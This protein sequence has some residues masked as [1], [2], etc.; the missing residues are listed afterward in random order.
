ML[1]KIV[2]SIAVLWTSI[3]L[4]LCLENM[5]DANPIVINIEHIDKVVHA[6]FHCI[7]A[8]LWFLFFRLHYLNKKKVNVYLLSFLFSFILGI[9]IEFLQQYFTTTR[10]VD[11]FD[12]L[13]NMFGATLGIIF[14][15]YLNRKYFRPKL[16]I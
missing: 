12:I 10:S 2:F 1:K 6:C 14:S 11:V 4:Y 8:A 16:S 7:L 9:L 5:R 15:V 13:A 3:V